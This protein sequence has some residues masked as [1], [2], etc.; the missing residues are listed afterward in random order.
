MTSPRI[1]NWFGNLTSQ[2][3]IVAHPHGVDELV[4][5]LRDC[6]RYPSPVRAVGSLH[7]MTECGMAEGGTAVLMREMN[8]I[9]AIGPETVTAEAGALYID[10]A[11]ELQKHGLQFYVNASWAT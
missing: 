11:K 2:P 4:A 7:S 10:V 9:L 3:R 8:R 1:N 6:K 5:I